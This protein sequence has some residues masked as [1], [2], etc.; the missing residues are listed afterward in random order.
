MFTPWVPMVFFQKFQ[1]ILSSRL[2]TTKKEIYHKDFTDFY[3]LLQIDSCKLIIYRK[4]IILI[5]LIMSLFK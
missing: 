5:E 2:A 3:L 1:P 4:K